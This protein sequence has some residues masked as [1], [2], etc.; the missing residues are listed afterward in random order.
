[1][2]PCVQHSS[3]KSTIVSRSDE[4]L[5]LRVLQSREK[6]FSWSAPW[7]PKV[8]FV[9]LVHTLRLENFFGYN[10]WTCLIL[11][12]TLILLQILSWHVYLKL[13]TIRYSTFELLRKE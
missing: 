6:I 8:K 2:W 7:E 11:G 12:G 10:H 4:S 5:V 9:D 1:M 13:I 3:N